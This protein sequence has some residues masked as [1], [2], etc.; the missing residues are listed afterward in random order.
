MQTPNASKKTSP[1][2]SHSIRSVRH[3][4]S[5]SVTKPKTPV[6][7]AAYYRAIADGYF[8]FWFEGDA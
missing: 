7:D 2:A 5:D 8:S 6:Q 1:S 3:R 4:P